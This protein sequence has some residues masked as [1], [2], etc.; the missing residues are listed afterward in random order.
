MTVKLKSFALLLLFSVMATMVQAQTVTGNVK[1]SQGEDIIGATIMEKG[2]RNGTVTDFDGNFTLKLTGSSNQLEVSYVGMKNKTVDVKGKTSVNVVLEDEATTLND[3]VVIGYGTVRKKDLTGAVAN[4]N[5]K[6]L[7]DIPVTSASEALTGK[8]AGVNITTTEGS[9]DADIKIRVRGGGSLSQDNSPLYIVDGFEVSS[10]SDIAPSEIESI[11]VLKDAS[12]TA[13]Y[14]ARGANG[15]IIV[16]TKSAKDSKLAIDFGASWGFKKAT[17]YNKVLSP[18]DYAMY[19]YELNSGSQSQGYV[20]GYG[21]YDDIEIWKSRSG[22]DF[23]DQIFGR[24]GS[25]QMYNVNVSGKQKALEFNVSY[26]HN[27]ENSIM[28]GSGYIKNNL[29]AK[30]KYKF[31]KFLTLD[32]NARLAHSNLEGL[33]GGADTN[34]SSAANSIVANAARF[35]PVNPLQDSIDDEDGENSG[36]VRKTP[37]ERISSTDKVKKTLNQNY[38]AALTWKP[39]KKWTLKTQWQYGW[40]NE[41]VEQVWLADAVTNSKYG[42][43][44]QPQVLLSEGKTWN[45]ST[46]NTITYDDKKLFG[47]RD[48]INVLLGQELKSQRAR[49]EE[50]VYVA[51]PDEFNG[52]AIT[53]G[54]VKGNTGIG[55]HYINF[56][57]KGTKVNMLSF[58]GRVNYTMMDKYLATFTMRA[59]AN[60]KF[61]KNNKWGY[62]PSLALAWRMS[63][64]EWLKNSEVVDNLKM[65]LS[66]GT[67]GNDRIPTG[68]QYVTSSVASSGSKYPWFDEKRAEMYELA[69]TM[70]NDNLKWETTI[71]RNFGIDFGFWKSRI[72]GSLDIYWNTTKDLLMKTEIPGATGYT[73]QYQNFGQTSNK[74]IELS[75]NAV[76][77]DTK[78]FALNFTGNIGYNQNKIDKLNLQSEWQSSNWGGLSVYEDYKVVEGGR[79]GEIWGYKLDSTHP[80]YTCWEAG[81]GGDL[82]YTGGKW[83][84]VV[85]VDEKGKPVTADP[86]AEGVN[87]SYTLFG[88]VLYPGTPKVE[89]NEDGSVKKQ[90]LGNTVA[91]VSGGFGFN[92]TFLKNFD[93]N[94][95]FNYSIGNK[96]VNGNKLALSY[97]AGSA[98]EYNLNGDFAMGNRYSWLDPETGMNLGR[99]SSSTTTYYGTSDKLGARLNEI[100]A[101]ANVWNPCGATAMQLIDY[102]VEDASF[103]RLQQITLGYTLPK[104]ILKK[105]WVKSLRI[106]ATAQNL[107]CWTSYSGNDPEVD[108]SSKKNAMCPGV[109][110]ASYPK[111]RTFMFGLNLSF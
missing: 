65:R 80:Y 44:G 5:S 17:G 38:S 25:Q 86:S 63:D 30:L 31:S 53:P 98:R 56:F 93:F 90:K 107:F 46:S 60:S 69:S 27:R 42:S 91:P 66:F 45:W 101:N 58:F 78:N 54:D 7:A 111:S 26:A 6:Q 51:F 68:I 13:I 37:Y 99:P 35:R 70:S 15:V 22:S 57:E 36:N 67:A 9:P 81:K 82:Y 87:K 49:T 1:D 14:G 76:I 77:A 71:T 74:G 96:I 106:Y 12:S 84:P 102:A 55:S 39:M 79:L 21:S 43:N 11:D 97:Y 83:L 92:G 100:N 59:D 61:G 28:Y 29:N 64:E 48:H 103:L 108:T 104:N 62:F 3:V 109:D 10:I 18:Y 34:E 75:L 88:G 16:T 110:Y 95:F 19:Q 52:H 94:I 85:G 47:G 50:N 72:S 20:S 24:T 105:Y 41:D 32:L 23:Q 73:Y 89:T 40:K 4:V 8:M 33:S 2:T